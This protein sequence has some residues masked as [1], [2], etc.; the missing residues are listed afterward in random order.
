MPREKSIFYTF[1]P[2][3]P[4][5]QEQLRAEFDFDVPKSA[6]E[7]SAEED[8][9]RQLAVPVF[10]RI[11]TNRA[12]YESARIAT[13]NKDSDSEGRLRF[14]DSLK[15]LINQGIID[16]SDT[17]YLNRNQHNKILTYSDSSGRRRLE[18]RNFITV[19]QARAILS[20]TM[21]DTTGLSAFVTPNYVC[22]THASQQELERLSKSIDPVYKH[23]KEG[24]RIIGTGRLCPT[25]CRTGWRGLV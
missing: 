25:L 1:K 18:S 9:I 24:E 6:E 12:Y 17:I 4:W 19:T 7:I 15:S 2:N 21:S 3:M 8:S 11:G 22:D 23:I 5:T 20:G 16:D 14:L 10:Q 13:F